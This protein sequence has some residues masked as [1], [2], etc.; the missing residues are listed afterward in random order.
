MI[1]KLYRT[2][3]FVPTLRFSTAT[4]ISKYSP[5][6]ANPTGRP[7]PRWNYLSCPIYQSVLPVLFDV[8]LRDGIQNADASKWTTDNKKTMFDYIYDTEHPTRMEVGSLVSPK[9]LPILGDSLE[10]YQYGIDAHRDV[11]VY[12][13]VPS[14]N[15]LPTALHHRVSNVSFI[16]STSNAFQKKNTLRTLEETKEELAK[17]DAE[18]KGIR[19]K[20]YISC[21]TECPI[22]GKQDLDYVLREILWYHTEYQM[23]ELC[24]SDTCGTMS[25]DDYEYLLDALLHFGVPASKLSLHLHVPDANIE[26][27]RR[28]LWYSFDKNVNK[29]DVSMVETG[30]CSVTLNADKRLPNLSYDLFYRVLDRYIQY[31][32]S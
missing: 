27:L 8:S 4:A 5:M 22:S 28:I 2:R 15:R 29:F 26:N 3:S 12:L 31:H 10:I 20:L 1:Q 16:T 24:L 11:E 6:M 23:D 17:M 14:L 7:M 13:L 19:K 21:I 18:T 32:L 30:G 9:V 25:F